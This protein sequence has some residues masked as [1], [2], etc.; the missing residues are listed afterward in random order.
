MDDKN[1]RGQGDRDRINLSENYE[2]EYWSGKFNISPE[3]LRKAVEESGSSMA[4]EVE[5]YLKR[6]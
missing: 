3:Q 2:V 4:A 1:N 6:Q 5:D